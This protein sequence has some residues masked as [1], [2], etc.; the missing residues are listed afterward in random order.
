[1]TNSD[2]ILLLIAASLFMTS[3][4]ADTHEG[5][6]RGYVFSGPHVDEWEDKLDNGLILAPNYQKGVYISENPESP[7]HHATFLSHGTTVKDADGKAIGDI[8]ILQAVDADGD[9][10]WVSGVQ[11]YNR[12]E[13]ASNWHFLDGTGKWSGITG[14]GSV[15]GSVRSRADDYN[16]ATWEIHWKVEKPDK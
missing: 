9:V 10:T 7:W 2:S 14:G 15:T 13:G 16:M 3:A 8:F 1:M 5:T 4:L 6:D 12:N 11:W